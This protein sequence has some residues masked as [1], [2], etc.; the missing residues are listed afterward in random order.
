MLK[1]SVLDHHIEGL[2]SKSSM[3]D[4]TGQLKVNF[5]H[6]AHGQLSLEGK[7]CEPSIYIFLFFRMNFSTK[8]YV[9]QS[10]KYSILFLRS[11]RVCP[12]PKQL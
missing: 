12:E 1:C 9:L 2:T 11:S 6:D 10:A 4:K 3:E 8:L 7:P 5:Q